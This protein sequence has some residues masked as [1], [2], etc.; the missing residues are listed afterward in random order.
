MARYH[1][2]S[3]NKQL[4]P[5]IAKSLS[6]FNKTLYVQKSFFLL[7]LILYYFLSST[8]LNKNYIPKWPGTLSNLNFDFF[9]LCPL[10][11]I[12]NIQIKYI[13]IEIV[14]PKE[15]YVHELWYNLDI[16]LFKM[17]NFKSIYWTGGHKA[18]I[19]TYNI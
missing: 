6:H 10:F 13:Q 7:S 2:L 11:I 3:P 1:Q 8:R 5:D 4:S 16:R 18:Y 9:R 19:I 14:P 12:Y 17:K 15:P